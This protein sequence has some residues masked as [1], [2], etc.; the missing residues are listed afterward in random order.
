MGVTS[1]LKHG[2]F[3][4]V[5][6]HQKTSLLKAGCYA[7]YGDGDEESQARE[8]AEEGSRTREW[9]FSSARRS[10]NC[11]LFNSSSSNIHPTNGAAAA[12]R[13][14]RRRI[15]KETER[16]NSGSRKAFAPK[17]KNCFDCV[18]RLTAVIGPRSR[19]VPLQPGRKLRP[20]TQPWPVRRWRRCVTCSMDDW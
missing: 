3:S 9:C 10:S 8:R 6:S 13:V 4:S 14:E 1:P 7:R 19:T 12:M 16:E 17:F 5:G 20:P 2:Q 11:S 15:L 18:F